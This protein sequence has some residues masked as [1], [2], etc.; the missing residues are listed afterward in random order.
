VNL[1][2]SQLETMEVK[3]NNS[4]TGKKLERECQLQRTDAKEE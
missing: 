1:R 2:D 4:S 3:N